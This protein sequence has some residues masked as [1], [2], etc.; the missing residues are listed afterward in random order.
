MRLFDILY[1]LPY[2][3][4]PLKFLRLF[5]N[6]QLPF[7]PDFSFYMNILTLGVRLFR[8]LYLLRIRTSVVFVL[9]DQS[10][11]CYI[12]D[13]NFIIAILWKVVNNCSS[14]FFRVDPTGNDS[15]TSPQQMP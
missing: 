10:K 12:L 3:F 13:S 4:V 5:R 15:A 6:I 9:K 1:L 14:Q 7:D 8:F 2:L 11:K